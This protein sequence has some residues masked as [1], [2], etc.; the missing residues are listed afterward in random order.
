MWFLVWCD[1]MELPHTMGHTGNPWNN[2]PNRGLLT[3]G[4]QIPI[5]KHYR[6]LKIHWYFEIHFAYNF[7]STE[8]LEEWLWNLVGNNFG[9][10][11][12]T[13]LSM[14]LKYIPYNFITTLKFFNLSW[15]FRW[16]RDLEWCTPLQPFIPGLS[17]LR[18]NVYRFH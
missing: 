11:L 10:I 8:Y 18:A 9:H 4:G 13:C 15:L 17:S 16:D 14:L 12:N 5:E 1:N 6:S 7:L 2:C 3:T